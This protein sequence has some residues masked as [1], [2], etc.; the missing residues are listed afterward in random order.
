[1]R[2]TFVRT[3]R[4]L[5]P[6]WMLA[7]DAAGKALGAYL[8]RGLRGA[9]WRSRGSLAT[10]DVQP[11]VS[12][13]DLEVVVDDADGAN[14][15]AVRRRWARLTRM[16][17]PLARLVDLAVYEREE[18]AAARSASTLRSHEPL[19]LVPRM[20][21]EADLRLRPGLRA[22]A[23]GPWLELQFLWRW[24][25]GACAGAP[26]AER[27]YQC[28]KLVSDPARIWLWIEHGE[29]P[30][31]R[32]DVLERALEVM[33]EEAESIE[34]ALGLHADLHRSAPA[35]LADTL[36]F[37]VRISA[38]I[39]ERMSAGAFADGAAEVRLTGADPPRLALRADHRDGLRRLTGSDPPL[40]PLADWRSR[41]W[42]QY[43][44]DAFAVTELD[45]ADPRAL[46]AAVAAGGDL[47]P[48]ASLWH[49]D[50]M[51]LAGPGILRAV[52][53]E[54][55]DPVSFALARGDRIA[56][57]PDTPGLSAADTAERALLEHRAWLGAWR[58]K[59]ESPLAAWMEAQNRTTT[60]ELQTIGWLLSASRAG[61]FHASMQAGEPEL[62]LTMAAAAEAVGANEEWATYAECRRDHL[63]PPQAVV[64]SLRERVLSLPGY[65]FEPVERIRA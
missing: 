15:T 61:L 58:E 32:R 3:G 34:R 9:E 33:P 13:L 21:D 17:S 39:A 37:C 53:C 56:C 55:F 36:P 65:A 50:L 5:R 29:D 48:F 24:V 40:L 43:P 4:A 28:V 6:L 62:C 45:P 1:M 18:L 8:T 23:E 44:D 38:R 22:G 25:L 14:R 54:A 10:G 7:Y 35:D 59:G 42:P 64:M 30:L 2:R 16:V 19:H 51:V 49:E 52:L 20:A 11:G 47:G 27:P 12:D 60:P 63:D 41:A 46:S 57:F 31:T 26:T